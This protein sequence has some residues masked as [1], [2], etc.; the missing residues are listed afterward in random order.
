MS[1][2]YTH[3]KT[4]KLIEYP[5]YKCKLCGQYDIEFP[6][7]ICRVCFWEDDSIQNEDKDYEGGANYISYNQYKELWENKPELI[8]SNTYTI[9]Q[10]Y[11]LYLKTKEQ[12]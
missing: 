8:T 3:K 6:H 9:K 12:K 7:D 4:G 10:A 11:E 1:T 5:P 2:Y